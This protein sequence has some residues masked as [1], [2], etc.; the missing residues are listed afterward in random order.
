MPGVWVQ[1]Y[2]DQLDEAEELQE[3][4]SDGCRSASR[5]GCW[6][7]RPYLPGLS[8]QVHG[9]KT[10]YERLLLAAVLSLCTSS[11]SPPSPASTASAPVPATGSEVVVTSLT[12]KP[13]VLHVGDKVT[14]EFALKNPGTN[15][16]PSRSYFFDL[17]IDGR[18]VAF[19]H[20]TA[21]LLSGLSTSYGMSPDHFNWQP[22]NA[23]LHHFDFVLVQGDRTNSTKGVI[24]GGIFRTF[25]GWEAVG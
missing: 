24:N 19:D 16:V 25:D 11:C 23:G 7:V 4:R 22:T 14:F 6:A 9:M 8:A 1:E 15:L 17:Y 18:V 20:T 2:E 12:H 5:D 10:K 13:N 21:D 3:S